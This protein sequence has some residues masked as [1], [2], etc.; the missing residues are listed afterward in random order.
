M[1]LPLVIAGLVF[2]FFFLGVWASCPADSSVML[3][4]LAC[5]VALP[6]SKALSKAH[7]ENTHPK[8]QRCTQKTTTL[9]ATGSADV[10]ENGGIGNIYAC[11]DFKPISALTLFQS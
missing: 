4:R 3:M 2:P 6:Q 8:T 1:S 10:L 7:V 9:P 5:F 11:S